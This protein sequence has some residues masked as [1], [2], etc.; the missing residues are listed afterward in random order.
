MLAYGNANPIRSWAQVTRVSAIAVCALGGLALAGWVLGVERL[1]AF[2][3]GRIP[4]APSTAVLFLLFGVL[5]LWDAAAEDL[6]PV[7]LWS[8]LAAATVGTGVAGVLLVLST[9]GISPGAELLGLEPS[10]EINGAPVGHMSPV[11]AFGFVVAGVAYVLLAVAGAHRR[12]RAAFALG[13]LLEL[14]GLTVTI[15]Y[16]LS[17][18]LLYQTGFIPPALTTSLA[19]MALGGAVLGAA[20]RRIWA[21]HRADELQPKPVYPVLGI[22][23]LTTALIVTPAYLLFRDYAAGVRAQVEAH[24]LS[25]ADMKAGQVEAWRVERLNDAATFHENAVFAGLVEAA[26][27]PG[28]LEAEGQIRSWLES[29]LAAYGYEE[30][31]VMDSTGR[32]RITV[33]DTAPAP[34]AEGPHAAAALLAMRTG[35]VHIEG[36]HRDEP[37]GHVHLT[38]LAP[39]LS[40]DG[41]VLGAVALSSDPANY[42]YPALAQWPLVTRTAETLLVRREGN[43]IVVL[44]DLRFADEAAL[45]VRFPTSDPELLAARAVLAA[46]GIIEGRDYRGKPAI[47]AVRHVPATEWWVVVRMD[48]DEAFGPLRTRLAWTV[49]LVLFLILAAIGLLGFGWQRREKLHYRELARSEEQYRTLFESAP[50]GI[51]RTRSDGQALA[52]NR[53]MARI[54]GFES[55]V[56]AVGHYDDL[57]EQLYVRPERRAEALRQLRENGFL[58]NFHY[59]ARRRDGTVIWM[60]MNARMVRGDPDGSFEIEGF[61]WD[62]TDQKAGEQTR[63]QQQAMLERTERIAGIGS[64]ELDVDTGTV[65]WSDEMF[66][67]F[68]RDPATGTPSLEEHGGFLSPSDMGRLQTVVELALSEGQPYNIELQVQDPGETVRQVQARGFPE[69]EPDGR[70]GRLYGLV[71]DVTEQKRRQER[72]AELG[73]QLNQAQ[74]MESVGR[75]AGGVA[76][77][78]NN[79]LS[80]ILGHVELAQ[81]TLEPGHVLHAD[82]A[83]IQQAGE[84][85]AKLTRQLLAF[86]REQVANPEVIELNTTISGMLG[87]LRRLIHEE[88]ELRW[89]PADTVWPV[90]VD[91]VQVSQVLA[92]L[93]INSRDAID[94][95]GRVTIATRNESVDENYAELHGDAVPGDYV[96]L[97]VADTGSGMDAETLAHVF[98]PFF[99]TKDPGKGTGLGLA[100]VYGIVRQNDGFITVYSEPGH[101]TIF[102][103]HLPRVEGAPSQGTRPRVPI[104]PATGSETVLVVEDQ[105]AVLGL[106][107]KILARLGYTVL[108]AESPGR[109]MELAR[110]HGSSIDLLITDVVMP[111][112]NGRELAERLTAEQ[113][114]LSILFM[115]GYAEDV[116]ADRGVIEAGVHF[117]EKPFTAAVFAAKVRL[118][119]AARAKAP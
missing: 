23:A 7:R 76:H 99:T 55:S 96:I 105:P 53:T 40:P 110:E 18:P 47:G 33:P 2:Q 32:I 29:V 31:A 83:Q 48:T 80:V 72:E 19:F 78:F 50:V 45:S 13:V 77:D 54:L 61:A 85:S 89:S 93:V 38:A 49:A 17:R 104:D 98:D 46:R 22:L 68:R 41:V 42:L 56:Q 57:A 34:S 111:E 118:A 20:A 43:D 88:V 106:V 58:E 15:A 66:R 117:V 103:V 94:A 67:I 97:T 101:G 116:I 70:V 69:M 100:T 91:P 108:T 27:Y 39:V 114:D 62:I 90:K 86:A 71:E 52:V 82:L 28:D 8:R 37:D 4:M 35:D 119:L 102:N 3:A 14:L 65:T 75:L 112:M 25:V 5:L 95:M 26:L 12:P 44:N 11:T 9:L 73:A 36:F 64:W 113:P 84:N 87:M 107:R 109:A 59:E 92:N 30:I 10:G 6:T 79:M 74:K 60:A 51:F 63:R 16:L 24:L 1:A 21:G 115:S 81:Q